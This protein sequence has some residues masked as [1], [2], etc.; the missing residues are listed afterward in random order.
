MWEKNKGEGHIGSKPTAF[1]VWL[2]YGMK[3]K[4]LSANISPLQGHPGK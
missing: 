2:I 1:Y 4:F 3:L